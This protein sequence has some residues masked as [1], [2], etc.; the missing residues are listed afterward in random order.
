MWSCYRMASAG[1][2][3]FWEN[4]I[5]LVAASTLKVMKPR[6]YWQPK[7]LTA[8]ISSPRVAKFFSLCPVTVY[9]FETRTYSM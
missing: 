8:P 4:M 9:Q 3:L 7:R 2:M 1:G 5:S 6:G